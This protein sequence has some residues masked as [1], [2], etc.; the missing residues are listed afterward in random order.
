MKKISSN[1]SYSKRVILI[2]SYFS[3]EQKI[4]SLV[5]EIGKN[6]SLFHFFVR[7]MKFPRFDSFCTF[8]EEQNVARDYFCNR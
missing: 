8:I 5:N 7:G 4:F 1:D 3:Y 6:N 2:Y